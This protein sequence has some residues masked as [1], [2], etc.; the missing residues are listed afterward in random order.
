M[1]TRAAV[2]TF[3]STGGLWLS[4]LACTSYG[5]SGYRLPQI[6]MPLSCCSP[7]T[8]RYASQ[9]CTLYILAG[10]PMPSSA[11]PS[12]PT[13]DRHSP[14]SSSLPCLPCA[15]GQT[16]EQ[17]LRNSSGWLWL[18]PRACLCCFVSGAPI[19]ENSQLVSSSCYCCNHVGEF[20]T[21][22][23]LAR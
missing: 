14:P 17:S 18:L 7:F 13:T 16:L 3:S 1:G 23:W 15:G 8:W 9:S 10:E 19:G 21:A 20:I 6:F 12:R 4:A 2:A 5:P 11:C 22:S